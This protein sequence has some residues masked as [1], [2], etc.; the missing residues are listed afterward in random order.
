MNIF[1][2]STCPVEAA[3]MQVVKSATKMCLE[4]AQLL[5]DAVRT[6]GYTGD[7]VYK[8]A[9]HNHPST[10]W[11]RRSRS[12]FLWLCDHALELCRLY[13]KRYGRIH[14]SQL[15]IERCLELSHLL[16][17]LPFAVG[18]DDLA[19]KS[20]PVGVQAYQ[21]FLTSNQTFDDAVTAYRKFYFQKPYVRK[22]NNV[23]FPS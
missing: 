15:V 9:Y 16:P 18:A 14:A 2:L 17:A 7:D 5:S 4:S 19:I 12:N 6:F 3:G 21:D 11:A 1:F 20:S 22:D 23:R 13:T 10:R 8:G